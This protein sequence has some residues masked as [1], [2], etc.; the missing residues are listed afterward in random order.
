MY[1]CLSKC[2]ASG[3][4]QNYLLWSIFVAYDKLVPVTMAWRVPRLR[5]EEWPPILILIYL[6][7]AIGLTP[8]GSTHL[9]INS[10]Q[11]VTV[12]LLAPEFYI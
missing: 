3:L 11:S 5:M 1:V 2:S 6:S 10:T 4:Y 7:T 8:G 12:N 9:H